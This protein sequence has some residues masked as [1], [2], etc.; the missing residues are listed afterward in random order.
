MTLLLSVVSPQTFP[1]SDWVTSHAALAHY[2]C[3]NFDTAQALYE[4]L[5]ERDPW[6]L[7]VCAPGCLGV[8]S[9]DCTLWKCLVWLIHVGCTMAQHSGLMHMDCTYK[10]L[11]LHNGTPWWV[12]GVDCATAL[13]SQ[14]IL[15][16]CATVLH[17]PC[18]FPCGPYH[19]AQ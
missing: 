13:R 3:R 4:D 5:L 8:D 9:I 7:Q 19:S 1:G 10:L 14:L 11:R 15:V 6:R 18:R 12:D 16:D 2:N 17:T